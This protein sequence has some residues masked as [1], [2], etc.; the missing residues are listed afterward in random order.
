MRVL[1]K[2]CQ[3]QIFVT[4]HVFQLNAKLENAGCQI[5]VHKHAESFT[6]TLTPLKVYGMILRIYLISG[7]N[8]ITD[9]HWPTIFLFDLNNQKFALEIMIKTKFTFSKCY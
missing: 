9:L 2:C 3:D 8:I 6:N 1:A 5:G 7:I 4:C